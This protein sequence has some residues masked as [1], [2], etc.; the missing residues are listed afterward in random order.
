MRQYKVRRQKSKPK[1]GRQA[2]L[3]EMLSGTRKVQRKAQ[4]AVKR[5]VRREIKTVERTSSKV[6][7]RT[8]MRLKI[9]IT[10]R[11]RKILELARNGA[12]ESEVCEKLGLRARTARV[13]LKYLEKLGLLK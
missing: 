13:E 10:G 3:T 1:A 2:K 7:R 4:I 12:T 11:N 8:K 6:Y 5:E 9:L